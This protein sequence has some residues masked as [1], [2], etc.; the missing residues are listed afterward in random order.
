MRFD[1]RGKSPVI[2]AFVQRTTLAI[3][4]AAWTNHPHCGVSQGELCAVW[5]FSHGRPSGF[6]IVDND[7]LLDISTWPNSWEFTASM[8]DMRDIGRVDDAMDGY[9]LTSLA[10]NNPAD[11]KWIKSTIRALRKRRVAA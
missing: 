6:L 2:S 8:N 9:F 10:R 7:G 11:E 3:D 4:G 1:L 5:L